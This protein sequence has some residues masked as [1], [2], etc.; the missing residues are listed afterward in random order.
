VQL[1][2]KRSSQTS[3]WPAR[4][5]TAQRAAAAQPQRRPS[6]KRP[7]SSWP[8]SPGETGRASP[9]RPRPQPGPGPGFL[10]PAWA[11]RSPASQGAILA[12][13]ADRTAVHQ[14]R[15]DKTPGRQSS[16]NPNPHFN[17]LLSLLSV[18]AAAGGFRGEAIAGKSPAGDGADDSPVLGSLALPFLCFLP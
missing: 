18:T 9:P 11:K 14:S 7:S 2:S 6:R 1:D 4:R 13:Q 12:V 10:H 15:G 17:S 5:P 3:P 8:L 16:R